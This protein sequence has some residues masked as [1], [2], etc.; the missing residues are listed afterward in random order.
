MSDVQMH[1]R[2]PRQ[3]QQTSACINELASLSDMEQFS[4]I[5]VLAVQFVIQ[6]QWYV[7]G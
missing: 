1:I 3:L 2:I 5:F 6:K 4:K 7:S